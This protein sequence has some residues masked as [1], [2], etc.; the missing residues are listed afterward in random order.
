MKEIS[1]VVSSHA[2]IRPCPSP[3]HCQSHLQGD[4]CLRYLVPVSFTMSYFNGTGTSVFSWIQRR[5]Q[6]NVFLATH[7]SRQ[8]SCQTFGGWELASPSMGLTEALTGKRLK[9]GTHLHIHIHILFLPC[10]ELEKWIGGAEK[11]E[12]CI[13]SP[14]LSFPPFFLFYSIALFLF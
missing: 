14:P 10:F 8:S 3:I 1:F 12:V 5:K 2:P 11:E 6:H 4:L 9:K 13:S 7:G